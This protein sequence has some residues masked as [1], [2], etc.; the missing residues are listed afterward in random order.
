MKKHILLI[1]TGGI[2][3]YKCL[4]FIRRARDQD[5]HITCVTTAA[6]EKFITPLS[7]TA[8]SGEPVYNDLFDRQAEADIGHIALA[9]RADLIVVAPATA[10]FLAKMAHGFAD[11][12][13]SAILLATEKPVL[14]APAM[15]P[16]MWH[17]PATQDN[18]ALLE[19]R[20][21]YRI[22]P[23]M[24]AMAEAE[25][26]MGRM[27]EPLE[28]LEAVNDLLTAQRAKDVLS[29]THS[30]SEPLSS[31]DPP[32]RAPI[33]AQQDVGEK[34]SLQGY[35]A[36]VTSGPTR[37]PIDPVR[38]LSNH[39]S[40]KQG[41]AIAAALAQRGA[42]TLLVTG[43]V[44]LPD[45]PDVT[46]QKVETAEEMLA[47]CQDALPRDIVVCAAAVADWRVAATHMQKL[48][49]QE[50]GTPPS[51]V[52][53]E[54]PDI[55]KT[56]SQMT[57]DRPSLVVGFAAETE[58]VLQHAI[59]KR[60]RKGCDWLV[61]N[62]VSPAMGTFGGDRNEI[63]LLDG[64]TIHSWPRMQKTDI[65]DRLAEE[66]AQYFRAVSCLE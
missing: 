52:L 15:N 66:I 20:G 18:L 3:A 7:L 47:A 50:S 25:T 40:G 54:N 33:D 30:L 1:L 26:G 60:L 24:G 28:I 22:G 43:P 56:I 17:H 55:L 65:A 53:S 31:L 23:G 61:A 19:K 8:I 46:V 11:S 44:S 10:D 9:R 35:R 58:N 36:L 51:L 32:A 49:K 14:I 27:A 29:F 39:S 16:S 12:L 13:A 5:Y 48:K 38:Y 63:H 37:E 4:E 6:A 57:E 2:A 34:T 42:E 41:H 62:D 59:A 45:P 21:I 64:A